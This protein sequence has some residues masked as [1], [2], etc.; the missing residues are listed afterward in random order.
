MQ[1]LIFLKHIDHLTA[2]QRIVFLYDNY[3]KINELTLLINHPE[4]KRC[5]GASE[6]R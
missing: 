6:P 5:R 4:K 3:S 2:H 1:V